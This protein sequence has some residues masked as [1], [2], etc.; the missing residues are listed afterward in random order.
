[1]VLYFYSCDRQFVIKKNNLLLLFYF[2]L[3]FKFE[4]IISILDVLVGNI[5]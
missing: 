2:K 5:H 3:F 4:N 1:M